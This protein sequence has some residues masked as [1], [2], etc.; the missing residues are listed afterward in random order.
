MYQ[1]QLSDASQPLG[2]QEQWQ[3]IKGETQEEQ[4]KRWQAFAGRNRMNNAIARVRY[5]LPNLDVT[6]YKP[7]DIVRA[8]MLLSESAKREL[9]VEEV[10]WIERFNDTERRSADDAKEGKKKPYLV[11]G[12]LAAAGLGLWVYFKRR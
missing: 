1:E 8:K 2:S 3:E 7:E 4:N 9:T 10:I 5:I 12:F 11:Y 6:K